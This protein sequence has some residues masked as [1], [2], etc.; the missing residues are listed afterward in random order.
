VHE[1]YETL[2]MALIEGRLGRKT[3]SHRAVD[4]IEVID[5]FAERRP[6]QFQGR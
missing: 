2:A 1:G 6:P 3:P 4:H 5:A